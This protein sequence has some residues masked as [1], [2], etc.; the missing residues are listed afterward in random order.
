MS[1]ST[2]VQ[3]YEV[4]IIYSW[5]KFLQYFVRVLCERVARHYKRQNILALVKKNEDIQ[6]RFSLHRGV[7]TNELF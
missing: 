2:S 4:A 3:S 5:N 1:N 7:A 6:I